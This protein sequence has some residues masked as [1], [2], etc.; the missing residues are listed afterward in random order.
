MIVPTADLVSVE[1][2]SPQEC[3]QEYLC[4]LEGSI[5]PLRIDVAYECAYCGSL[6]QSWSRAADCSCCWSALP[7]W[8]QQ[9]TAPGSPCA[10]PIVRRRTTDEAAPE[11]LDE[12][13]RNVECISGERV[14]VT[15]DSMQRQLKIE[16]L[17]L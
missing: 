17:E 7:S 13:R 12:V 10:S 11:Y 8:L 3:L 14:R 16:S 6:F 4:S 2:R 15:W 9:D 1:T 5:V